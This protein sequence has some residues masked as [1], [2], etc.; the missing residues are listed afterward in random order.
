MFETALKNLDIID[1]VISDNFYYIKFSNGFVIQGGLTTAVA[2][3][4]VLVNLFVPMSN[5]NYNITTSFDWGTTAQNGIFS[6]IYTGRSYNAFTIAL[7]GRTGSTGVAL[8]DG[9]ISW[10]VCGR[11]A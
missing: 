2:G 9:V 1:Y 5:S 3:Q 6:P 11:Y 8:Y 4:G 10:Q 7:T